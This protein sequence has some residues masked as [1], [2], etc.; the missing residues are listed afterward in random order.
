MVLYVARDLPHHGR[1][2]FVQKITKQTRQF[3]KTKHS[4]TISVT[5]SRWNQLPL[6]TVCIFLHWFTF[7]FRSCCWFVPTENQFEKL[8]HKVWGL[9][10]RENTWTVSCL[11]IQFES[12]WRDGV[13]HM[14][15]IWVLL[16]ISSWM[17][18]FNFGWRF[19]V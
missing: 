9:T 7:S 16:Q 8:K 11:R 1:A 4:S 5:V 19:D 14:M 12:R 3:A 18:N 15:K 10:R 6:S 13:R 2:A 17:R